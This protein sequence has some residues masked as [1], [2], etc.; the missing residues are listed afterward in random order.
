MKDSIRSA[1]RESSPS[2]TRKWAHLLADPGR[3]RPI[4]TV[5]RAVDGVF[6]RLEPV[7]ARF[8]RTCALLS[9]ARRPR[10][11][12]PKA[13]DNE[14]RELGRE[15][16]ATSHRTASSAKT[17]ELAKLLLPKDPRDDSNIFLEVRAGTG[18][19]EA[20]IFAGDL[21]R[22]YAR[23][24]ERQGW[25][26]EVLSARVPASTAATRRSSAASSAGGAFSQLQVRVRHASRA[27]RAGDRSAGPHP[28]LGRAP[29]RSC[30]SSTRS[31]RSSSIPAELRVDTFRASGAG[32]QHVNK[33]DSAI[34]ITHL[35]TGIVVECQ[36]ERSQH[37]NRSRAMALL[38]ARLLGGASSEKRDRPKRNRAS[39]R[40]APATAPSASAPTTSRRAASPTTA[41]TSR[42]TSSR[43][44]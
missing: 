7:V 28:H 42:C 18:G 35:P 33:T 17:E 21:F 16:L 31:T 43:T 38:K 36:D 24:A 30:R 2:A 6:A 34:R 39:C 1:T 10:R 3:H 37:K 8:A 15:E 26:V 5:P 29:W 19:D 14:L 25:R 9:R 44:S 13:P 41:S 23:Y 22:M 11:R 4:P 32:G 40:S 20:A 12:W 27:A